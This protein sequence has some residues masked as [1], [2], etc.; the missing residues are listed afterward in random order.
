[1]LAR[2]LRSSPPFFSLR[3]WA[4][5]STR[6]SACGALESVPRPPASPSHNRT[7][8]TLLLPPVRGAPSS[9]MRSAR[10]SVIIRRCRSTRITTEPAVFEPSPRR[11]RHLLDQKMARDIP[12]SYNEEGTGTAIRRGPVTWCPLVSAGHGP[13]KQ[14]LL[15]LVD[16]W[17]VT[18]PFGARA[19]GIRRGIPLAARSGVEGAGGARPASFGDKQNKNK[20][21]GAMRC[22]P[23]QAAA[24][25]QRD[26]NG[27]ERGSC[28]E[29]ACVTEDGW[30][31]MVAVDG[32][33]WPGFFLL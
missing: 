4:V 18:R 13:H 31:G 24:N 8:N 17:L 10:G 19:A 16:G 29:A 6:L 26:G 23:S 32:W 15:L 28:E 20:P 12:G 3:P 22:Q 25:A 2:T 33:I 5:A 7:R 21:G 1:M 27:S 11:R 9:P 30:R 14:K